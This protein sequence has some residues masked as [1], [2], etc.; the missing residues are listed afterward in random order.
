MTGCA[1]T[2]DPVFHLTTAFASKDLRGRGVKQVG[3]HFSLAPVFNLFS[4]KERTKALLKKT[5]WRLFAKKGRQQEG[6]VG[7]SEV[8]VKSSIKVILLSSWHN[9]LCS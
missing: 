4:L 3:F 6:A 9:I 8:V 5:Q 1:R 7:H 2:E